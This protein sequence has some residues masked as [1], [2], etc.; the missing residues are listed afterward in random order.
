MRLLHEIGKIWWRGVC[1]EI[2]F[3]FK[4]VKPQS[5]WDKKYIK[6]VTKQSLFLKVTDC[7]DLCEIKKTKG[8]LPCASEA[9]E[10]IR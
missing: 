9:C 10:K 4:Y 5:L 7:S 1:D 3:N 8:M 6:M 2:Q